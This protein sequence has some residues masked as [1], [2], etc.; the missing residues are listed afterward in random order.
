MT[1]KRTPEEKADRA[2]YMRLYRLSKLDAERARLREYTSRMDVKE[3]RRARDS[4]PEK[5]AKRR[6]HAAT[7]AAKQRAK[8]RLKEKKLE[9]PQWHVQRIAKQRHQRTG[10]T[11]EL[12]AR[13]LIAQGNKCAVC[14]RSF[15]GRQVRADHCHDTGKPRGLLCHHCNIMEGM[16]KSMGLSPEEFAHNL[17]TYLA[18]PALQ[19]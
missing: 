1:T 12:I 5:L 6:E 15:E 7:E 8:E 18:K 13:T 4:T 16:L 3:R 9:D 17:T 11:P 19:P 10:F 2:E 14:W